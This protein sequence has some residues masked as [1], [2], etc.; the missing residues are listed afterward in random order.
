MVDRADVVAK[1]G[2]VL[3]ALPMGAVLV[4]DQGRI[5]FANGEI[6]RLFGYAPGELVGFG[7]DVLVPDAARKRHETQRADYATDLRAR[8]MGHGR[9]LSGRRKDGVIIP[10]EVGLSVV[11]SDGTRFTLALVADISE[12]RRIEAEVREANERFR[13]LAESIH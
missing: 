8:P 7:V 12:R 4:D 6:G 3:D 2:V 10:V 5:A 11:P 1:L 13:Q 9:D